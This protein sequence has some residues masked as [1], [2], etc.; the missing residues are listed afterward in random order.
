MKNNCPCDGCVPPK[1]HTHCH[2]KCPDHDKW[3]KKEDEKASMIRKKKQEEGV[4]TGYHV[5]VIEKLRK[6][7]K[8]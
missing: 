4:L 7:R 5:Q 2:E 1:R 3:R 6:R 8:K